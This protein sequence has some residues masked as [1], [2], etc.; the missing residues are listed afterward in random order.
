L[1]RVGIH[2]SGVPAMSYAQR[3]IQKER[4]EYALPLMHPLAV[5]Q[6]SHEDPD[7]RAAAMLTISRI[8]ESAESHIELV[9]TMMTT[10]AS[11]RVREFAA[12]A[13]RQIFT[14]EAVVG[15]SIRPHIEQVMERTSPPFCVN[16]WGWDTLT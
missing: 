4:G 14:G 7:E 5:P 1:L 8:G 11:L 9:A 12:I 6:L 13:L 10:D 3:F 2:L 16:L 15:G